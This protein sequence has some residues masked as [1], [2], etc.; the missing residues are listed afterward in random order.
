MQN[1]ALYLPDPVRLKKSI[2]HPANPG[3]FF[4]S[5]NFSH[6]RR[7]VLMNAAIDWE[8]IKKQKISIGTLI[9]VGGFLL[10]AYGPAKGWLSNNFVSKAQ[11]A[12]TSLIITR[13]L[14]TIEKTQTDHITEYRID[15]ALEGVS[16]FENKLYYMERDLKETGQDPEANQRWQDL[17]TDLQRAEQ[18][19]DCL[20]LNRPNCEH[21]NRR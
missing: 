4:M 14:D 19:R 13:Q 8:T 9:I 3:G 21:L 7:G 15:R 6:T 10:W 16:R 12:E 5:R 20:L 18:Y 2:T 17:S 1:L 11:A